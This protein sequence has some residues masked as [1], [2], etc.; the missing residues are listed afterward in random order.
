MPESAPRVF[1]VIHLG[2]KRITMQILEY[3]SLANIRTL[4]RVTKEVTLG[5]EAFKTGRISFSSVQ[6]TC[7]LLR[8]LRRLLADYGVRD[9]RLLATTAIR[10]AENRRYIVDQIRLRSGLKAEVIDT[11]QEAFLIFIGIHRALQEQG[12][13]SET[14]NLLFVD[15]SSGGLSFT[16]YRG[17]QLH[18]QQ[19]IHIGALRIKESF[20]KNRR[21]SLWFSEALNEY[22]SATI[23]PVKWELRQQPTDYLVLSGVETELL[24]HMLH[25]QPDPSGINQIDR[26]ELLRL[27]E[28]VSTLN[29]PQLTI[30]FDLSEASAELVLPT[31]LLYRQIVSISGVKEILVPRQGLT[32]GVI[33]W[34]VMN[35]TNDPQ[36]AVV[37]QQ[38]VETAWYLGRKYG[39]ED[40][41][42][43]QV[44]RF[45]L[46]LYDKL[47]RR[48]GLGRRERLLLQVAAILHDIGKHVCLRRHYFYSYRLIISSDI[49]GFSEEE[50]A[51]I[52]NVAYYHSQG[53]P[54]DY[55]ANFGALDEQQ[56][57]V[58]A[59]LSAILRLADAL[60]RGHRQK[61]QALELKMHG[62]SLELTVQCDRDYTLE[63]W[64][65]QDVSEFFAAVFGVQ[66][67]MRR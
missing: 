35:Q 38:L 64:T 29:I 50:K 19:N 53:T 6:E 57:V 66:V 14:R 44:E 40:A 9:Y 30:E 24:L 61:V 63:E 43:R 41:H 54:T 47:G 31:I 51:I 8:G 11:T 7:E 58:V 55:D 60:D 56:K 17:N 62:D 13:T 20:T 49:P 67:R 34:Q 18:C 2:S 22:I 37:E 32:E 10:E 28:R 4:D 12:L 25:R 42:A 48:H 46:L 3:R 23:E 33:A 15:I 52:A 21:E 65:V 26:R 45:G 59:K 5:E 1:A 16:Y 27:Y 39:C 36:L